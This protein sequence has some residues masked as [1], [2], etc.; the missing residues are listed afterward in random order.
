MTFNL[1]QYETDNAVLKVIKCFLKLCKI[2][3]CK[4]GRC[5]LC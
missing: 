3:F 2:I 5:Y 4:P 1:N